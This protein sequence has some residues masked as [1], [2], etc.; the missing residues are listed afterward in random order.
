MFVSIILCKE[1]INGEVIFMLMT[2]FDYLS[3]FLFEISS[4]FAFGCDFLRGRQHLQFLYTFNGLA[5]TQ[6]QTFHF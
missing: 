5:I 3:L 2:K 4:N 6:A 1:S